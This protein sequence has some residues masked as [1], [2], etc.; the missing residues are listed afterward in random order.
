MKIAILDDHTLFLKGMLYLIRDILPQAEI[1][2]YETVKDI[3]HDHFIFKDLNLIVSDIDLPGE[4]VFEL[5]NYSK[6]H[7]PELPILVISMHKKLAVIRKCKELQIEGYILKNEDD[8]FPRAVK[9]LLEGQEYF[10]PALEVF[11]RR[12]GDNLETLSGREEDIIKLIA[13][14]FNNQ[15]IA[16]ELYISTETVKTHKKNIKIKLGVDSTHDII[17]YTKTNYLL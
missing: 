11:Y 16:D 14:G 3:L 15:E 17:T 8:L 9:S 10:S 5:F 1:L 2:T 12:A 13:K 4:D 7:F 6:K